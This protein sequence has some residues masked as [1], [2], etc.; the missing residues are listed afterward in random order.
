MSKATVMKKKSEGPARRVKLYFNE[1]DEM[2]EKA[3]DVDSENDEESDLNFGKN[4]SIAEIKKCIKEKKR[5]AALA[6]KKSKIII[7]LGR[8]EFDEGAEHVT[9]DIFDGKN[10]TKNAEIF[11]DNLIKTK[12]K[13][14]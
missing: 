14:I 9:R 1:N 6:G 12:Q 11:I 7:N 5:R 3:E 2:I 4:M 13:F 10:K 8:E